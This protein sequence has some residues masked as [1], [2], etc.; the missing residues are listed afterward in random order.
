MLEATGALQQQLDQALARHGDR[1]ALLRELSELA[2]QAAF[3]DLAATWAP[4]LYARDATFFE[5]FLVRHL[6]APPH[7]AIIEELLRRAEADGCDSLFQGLYRKIAQEDRWDAD[8]RAL[9]SSNMPDE[10]VL[11]AVRRRLFRGIWFGLEETTALA[12]YRRNPALFGP[13]IAQHVRRRWFGWGRGKHFARL[14]GEALARGDEELAL[15]VFR[16]VADEAMWAT[17]VK[18]L[19]ATDLPP[20]QLVAALRRRHPTSVWQFDARVLADVVQRC[21]A[22]AIPYLEQDVLRW[23][24]GDT[25]RLLDAV[26][27]TGDEPAY[28]RLFLRVAD[29]ARWNAE[30]RSLLQAPLDD[31]ALVAALQPR[32]PTARDSWWQLEDD[33]ALALYRRHPAAARPLLERLV[34]EPAPALWAAA[35]AS[36]D[37]ELL[38]LLSFRS[39]ERC[40]RL[41]WRAF[42][43]PSQ[44]RWSKPDRKAAAELERLS[45]PVLARFDRLAADSPERYVRHAAEI[46]SYLEPFEL[47]SFGRGRLHNPILAALADRH[48]EAWLASS[49]AMRELLESPNIFVQILGLERLATG[50]TDAARRTVE[51][52]RLLR[53]L[54]FGRARVGTKK[55]V[56]ACLEWAARQDPAAA[57]A[58]LPLLGEAVDVRGKR[59]VDLRAMVSLVRLRYAAVEG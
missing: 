2:E 36:G 40:N 29:P 30:L 20:E 1:G 17:E 56:L 11:R 25:R 35:E 24:R 5:N 42:P 18:R 33:V 43:T 7:D 58:V 16:A 41:A 45:A 9:A 38:D 31:A 10:A 48:H 50:G 23:I 46:L 21:G 47:W 6:D 44:Q 59:A 32:I 8:L 34:R 26:R 19:L 4:E 12:L 52:L 51:N 15:A 55:L 54:L 49:A 28:W 57:A 27:N 3:R 14:R 37:E 39:L 53:A 13:L 22:A